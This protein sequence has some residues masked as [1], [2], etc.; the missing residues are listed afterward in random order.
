MEIDDDLTTDKEKM[1]KETEDRL[2]LFGGEFIEKGNI[3]MRICYLKK[4]LEVFDDMT[5]FRKTT[6]S[7][8][9]NFTFSIMLIRKALIIFYARIRYPMRN[10]K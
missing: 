5:A 8:L 7:L 6:Y 4:D 2:Y 10:I 1:L 9:R 3:K